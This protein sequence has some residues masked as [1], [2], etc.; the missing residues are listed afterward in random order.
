MI[1]QEPGRVH[2]QRKLLEDTSR[3]AGP[4]AQYNHVVRL[5][6]SPLLFPSQAFQ[7]V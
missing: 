6:Y 1:V 2:V 4:R 7:N 5:P 3:H